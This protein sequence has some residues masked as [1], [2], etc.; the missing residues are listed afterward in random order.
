MIRFPEGR[1]SLSSSPRSRAL[2][3]ARPVVGTVGVDPGCVETRNKDSRV[4]ALAKSDAVGAIQP[5]SVSDRATFE[6]W[7][8]TEAG[9]S[10]VSTH[11]GPKGDTALSVNRRVVWPEAQALKLGSYCSAVRCR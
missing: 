1:N 3:R 6:M 11:P 2:S 5:T 7:L 4:R 10:R 9:I 8:G